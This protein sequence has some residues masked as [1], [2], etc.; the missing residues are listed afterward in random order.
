MTFSIF[1]KPQT[2][3]AFSL[4]SPIYREFDIVLFC[5]V[6]FFFT[7]HCDWLRKHESSMAFLLQ[8]PRKKANYVCSTINSRELSYVF[9]VL[10][11]SSADFYDSTAGIVQKLRT[12]LVRL[13][14]QPEHRIR[15]LLSTGAAS[16]ITISC[17]VFCCSFISF[18]ARLVRILRKVCY[19]R[20]M[21]KLLNYY[22][23]LYATRNKDSF[24]HSKNLELFS[25]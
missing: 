25:I 2:S 11:R 12:L 7:S 14:S 20:T 10:S 13:G 8:E 16:D 21:A 24:V 9:F 15:S 4:F 23:L 22:V 6:L 19:F 5:F 3:V 1:S 18:V 17:I